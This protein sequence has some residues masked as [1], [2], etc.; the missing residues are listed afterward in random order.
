M[1]EWPLGDA[2]A[3]AVESRNGKP[4]SRILELDVATQRYSERQWK[5]QFE[6]AGHVAADFQMLGAATGLVIER[7]DATEGAGANCLKAGIAPAS[8]S[9]LSGPEFALSNHFR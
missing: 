9:G 7:D 5:Y 6:E 8:S 4:Y 2:Q 3:E 1:F